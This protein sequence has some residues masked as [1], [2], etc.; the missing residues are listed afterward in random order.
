MQTSFSDLEFAAKKK[1][2]RRERF[3]CEIDALVPWGKLLAV[4]SPFYPKG[5]GRG[6]PPVGLE[7][8]LRLYV[9][10]QCFALSDEGIEDAVYDS[11]AI[12]R[13]AGIDLSREGAPDATTVLHFRHLL[14]A[15]GLTRGVFAAIKDHLAAKGL[16]LKEGTI[17]DATIIAAPPSTKNE[18]GARDP[19]MHQTKKGNAW[20]FG[21]KAHIGVDAGSGL[22]HSLV[23]TP[24]NVSDVTK[25]HDL[26]HGEE[27]VSFGDA[28]YQGVEKRPEAGANP[29]RWHV[30]MRGETA[31]PARYAP[32]ATHGA[33]GSAEG[34]YQGQGRASVPHHQEQVRIET[35]T[36]QGSGQEHR[37]TLH[38]VWPSQPLH[39]QKELAWH[40]MTRPMV[41]TATWQ[42]LGRQPKHAHD[43]HSRP[44]R[45]VP[46]HIR[47]VQCVPRPQS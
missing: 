9:V 24:A 36:L 23:A 14:E 37:P 35:Y 26:L 1:Q 16:L 30:A 46:V 3:L 15:H 6:R 31:C 27:T 39:R 43:T 4:I 40:G 21:M 29:V 25:A 13:F 22:V 32:G 8:M 11:Q 42:R 18:T 17:V 5:G 33:D 19:E 41:A 20:H 38:F 12:R 7:R 45:T 47:I 10:Q 34:Q 2:T 44:G 28:G